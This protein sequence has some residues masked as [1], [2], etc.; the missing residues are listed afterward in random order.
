MKIGITELLKSERREFSDR[1]LLHCLEDAL[2]IYPLTEVYKEVRVLKPYPSEITDLEPPEEK[3]IT[4]WI[5]HLLVASKMFTLE[6][7]KTI[8]KM[9]GVDQLIVAL[10]K[11]HRLEYHGY[12]WPE[13]HGRGRIFLANPTSPAVVA[14]EIGHLWGLDNEYEEGNTEKGIMNLESLK[15]GASS[16]FSLGNQTAILDS[17]NKYTGLGGMMRRLHK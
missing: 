11:D 1:E 8:R 5:A 2:N 16:T 17:H 13:G 4:D 3:H 15:S 6:Q 9:Y 10:G 12:A 7:G 14:H